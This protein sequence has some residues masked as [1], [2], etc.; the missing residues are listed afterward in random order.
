MWA[1]GN[2]SRRPGGSGFGGVRAGP[3]G[4]GQPPDPA[5]D[6]GLGEE[7]AELLPS[8]ER[9]DEEERQERDP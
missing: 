7:L 3:S 8:D 5:F 2:P 9:S 1:A 6:D 4:F